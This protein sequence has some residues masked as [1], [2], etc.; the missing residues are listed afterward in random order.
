MLQMYF[1]GFRDK[2]EETEEEIDYPFQVTIPARDSQE[3]SSDETSTES[4]SDENLPG[5]LGEFSKKSK[6]SHNLDS[7]DKKLTYFSKNDGDIIQ[8]KEENQSDFTSYIEIIQKTGIGWAIELAKQVQSEDDISKF[9][10][11][12]KKINSQ[13]HKFQSIKFASLSKKSSKIIR[14]VQNDFQM[15]PEM[16]ESYSSPNYSIFKE[17][18]SFATSKNSLSN[19]RK[20]HVDESSDDIFLY[21]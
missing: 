13:S 5:L 20:F 10:S 7:S 21:K 14:N 8:N 16:G 9:H 3:E 19:K 18:P 11:N 2:D 12:G 1:Q 6:E 15:E 4:S 17:L